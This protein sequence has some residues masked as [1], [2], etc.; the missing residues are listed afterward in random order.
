MD[1]VDTKV[2]KVKIDVIELKTDVVEI[3]I[4][5]KLLEDCLKNWIDNIRAGINNGVVIWLNSL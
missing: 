5:M 3:K 1:R 2:N 4:K